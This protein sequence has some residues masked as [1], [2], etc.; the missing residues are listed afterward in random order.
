M[1]CCSCDVGIHQ[2]LDRVVFLSQ[3]ILCGVFLNSNS[4]GIINLLG[5]S[6]ELILQL[7]ALNF[8]IQTIFDFLFECINSSFEYNGLIINIG[9]NTVALLN[10]HLLSKL[11][12][13]SL[14]VGLDQIHKICTIG[15]LLGIGRQ[16]LQ[17]RQNV[18]LIISLIIQFLGLA[19]SSIQLGGQVCNSH[20]NAT[21]NISDECPIRS[22]CLHG[23]I[24]SH[25][26]R[27]NIQCFEVNLRIEQ[28]CTQILGSLQLTSDVCI[29]CCS[30]KSIGLQISNS[31]LDS[32]KRFS[33]ALLIGLECGSS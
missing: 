7:L 15:N 26:I 28:S 3:I 13:I 16:T 31:L 20:G 21:I 9:T 32:C 29:Q 11:L 1:S 30:S 22:T 10:I 12:L 4:L 18:S 8:T 17:I 19:R 5:D 2:V 14:I 27:P 24:D 33:I 25:L 6:V 23:L